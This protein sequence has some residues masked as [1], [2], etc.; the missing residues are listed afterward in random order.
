M[1][2]F[3]LTYFVLVGNVADR[4]IGRSCLSTQ[5]VQQNW[6]IEPFL[7][8]TSTPCRFHLLKVYWRPKQ[9]QQCEP[10]MT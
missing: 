5:S 3:K 6:A 4:S 8:K 10:R 7:A 9:K 2:L 1:D